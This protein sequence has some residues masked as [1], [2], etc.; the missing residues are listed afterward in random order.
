ME[1]KQRT[2]SGILFIRDVDPAVKKKLEKLARDK[3]MSL[4]GYCK[5]VLETHVDR[6]DVVDMDAKYR[7]LVEDVTGMYV[8]MVEK[9]GKTI[10]ENTYALNRF[11]ER[12]DE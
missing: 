9:A 10:E 2:E 1:K 7:K 12:S 11:A 4:S 3:K 8:S 5:S 6:I